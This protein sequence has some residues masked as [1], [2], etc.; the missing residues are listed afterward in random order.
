TVAV[1]VATAHRRLFDGLAGPETVPPYE[2]AHVGDGRLFGR[3]VAEMERLLAAHD[4]SVAADAHEPA[5]H[6]AIELALMARLVSH[7]HP[8][9]ATFAA[10][11]TGWIPAF[12]RACEAHDRAGFHAAAARLLATLVEREA[13]HHPLA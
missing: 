13:P 6:L 2:S 12:A 8:D 10:R 11:L 4:L 1:R 9:R 3:P 7:D 5:D